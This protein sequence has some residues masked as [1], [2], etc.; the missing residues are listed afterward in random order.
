[1][2]RLAQYGTR[3]DVVGSQTSG[4]SVTARVSRPAGSTRTTAMNPSVAVV[5]QAE[6][7][8]TVTRCECRPEV[9]RKHIIA[10]VCVDY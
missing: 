2:C 3:G 6:E 7:R 1:V 5:L 8:V 4:G 9:A 10:A